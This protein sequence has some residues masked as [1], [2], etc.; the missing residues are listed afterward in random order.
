[1]SIRAAGTH[2]PRSAR[3]AL[4]S[5]PAGRTAFRIV[6]GASAKHPLLFWQPAVY[7]RL[8]LPPRLIF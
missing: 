4:H 1:M 3:R 7:P 2:L 5:K 8:K 6:Q